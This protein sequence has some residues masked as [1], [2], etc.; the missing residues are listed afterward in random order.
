MRK[1]NSR[2]SH[3]NHIT[4]VFNE[5]NESEW[6]MGVELYG[7]VQSSNTT[8]SI[9][10]TCYTGGRHRRCRRG[11]GGCECRRSARFTAVSRSTGQM[12]PGH[13]TQLTQPRGS[14][15]ITAPEPLRISGFLLL[16]I[17]FFFVFFTSP[18]C[19]H[20]PIC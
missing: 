8:C 20:A 10:S 18:R 12:G 16:C 2:T 17:F 11:C 13:G 3:Q 15:G 9:G 5:K 19:R 7:E 4:I 1:S 14:Y 6:T